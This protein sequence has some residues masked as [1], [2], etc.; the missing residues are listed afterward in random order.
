MS[1]VIIGGVDYKVND[2]TEYMISSLKDEWDL[3]KGDKSKYSAFVAK[4]ANS[5]PLPTILKM[6]D[7]DFSRHFAKIFNLQNILVLSL[8]RLHEAIATLYVNTLE[9]KGANFDKKK[10]RVLARELPANYTDSMIKLKSVVI[11]SYDI[12]T[13]IK[14]EYADEL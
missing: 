8:K 12:E 11:D 13:V 7:N 5:D 4:L 10:L 6:S 14:E 1:K 9:E 2:V 3:I